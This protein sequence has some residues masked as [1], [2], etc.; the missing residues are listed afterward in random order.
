MTRRKNNSSC[1]ST[2]SSCPS[3]C[4]SCSSSCSTSS[5]CSGKVKQKFIKARGLCGEPICVPYAFIKKKSHK[6]KNVTP[7]VNNILQ[8]EIHKKIKVI[9]A[10]N[11]AL[12]ETNSVSIAKK[13]ACTQAKISQA[14]TDMKLNT[15][16][17]TALN[18][19]G[20]TSEQVQNVLNNDVANILTI[21]GSSTQ[22]LE[23][24]EGALVLGCPP[25]TCSP[26]SKSTCPQGS[27]YCPTYRKCIQ[28]D[29][30]CQ[31]DPGS[32]FCRS[33]GSCIPLFMNCPRSLNNLNEPFI[34]TRITPVPTKGC[35][36]CGH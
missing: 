30:G 20:E 29:M 4:S 26:S 17:T 21:Q 35:S 11:N 22:K 32:F 18:T 3:S 14:I 16:L 7:E 2:S 12:A 19:C 15:A 1:F 5:S 10:Q 8:Q 6:R 9:Q 23:L 36:G 24:E 28:D 31:C 25:P 13:I 33:Y 27:Y 34:S